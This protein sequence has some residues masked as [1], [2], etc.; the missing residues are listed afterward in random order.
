MLTCLFFRASHFQWWHCVTLIP[1]E[2]PRWIWATW[3]KSWIAS[4]LTPKPQQVSDIQSTLSKADT[5]GTKATVRFREMSAFE[6]VQLQRYKCNSAGSGPNLLSGLESVRLERVDCTQ[7]HYNQITELLEITTSTPVDCARLELP[8]RVG[9]SRF[10]PQLWPV[11][12]FYS[13]LSLEYYACA[14]EPPQ[15]PMVSVTG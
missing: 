14:G 1:F 10:V 3:R 8:F 12:P 5:L 13:D 9:C 4:K 6:R 15:Q 7:R 2:F 11:K